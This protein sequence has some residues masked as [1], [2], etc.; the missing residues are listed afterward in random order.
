LFARCLSRPLSRALSRTRCAG[1]VAPGLCR[2]AISRLCLGL[3]RPRHS[4]LSPRLPSKYDTHGIPPP[5]LYPSRAL[6][7]MLAVLMRVGLGRARC[8]G[9]WVPATSTLPPQAGPLKVFFARPA[10]HLRRLMSSAPRVLILVRAFPARLLVGH[11]LP[12]HYLPPPFPF[13]SLAPFGRA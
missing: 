7:A 11:P 1:P 4:S 9:A 6:A 13:P 5:V 3:P 10:P 2:G 8:R 12:C